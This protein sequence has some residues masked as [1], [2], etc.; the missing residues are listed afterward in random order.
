MKSSARENPP[1]VHAV[2]SCGDRF[3]ADKNN[4]IEAAGELMF[5]DMLMKPIEG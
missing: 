4:R 1:D 2:P 5:S 3:C